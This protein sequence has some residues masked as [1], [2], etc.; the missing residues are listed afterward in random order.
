M[1]EIFIVTFTLLLFIFFTLLKMF[2]I[3]KHHSRKLIDKLRPK[4][5]NNEVVEVKR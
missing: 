2:G 4:V 1:I 3:M 5:D